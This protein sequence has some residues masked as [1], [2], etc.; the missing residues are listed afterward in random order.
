MTISNYLRNGFFINW[1]DIAMIAQIII[2]CY[3]TEIG[4]IFNFIFCF[5]Q[6]HSCCGAENKEEENEYIED[7]LDKACHKWMEFE[8]KEI[9]PEKI[10]DYLTESMARIHNKFYFEEEEENEYGEYKE[11]KKKWE[12]INKMKKIAIEKLIKNINLD[13]INTT[14]IELRDFLKKISQIS[15][16]IANFYSNTYRTRP[17]G[18]WGDMNFIAAVSNLDLNWGNIRNMRALSRTRNY[19]RKVFPYYFKD[20]MARGGISIKELFKIAGSPLINKYEEEK[21]YYIEEKMKDMLT[22]ILKEKIIKGVRKYMRKEEPQIIDFN[23]VEEPEE[24]ERIKRIKEGRGDYDPDADPDELNKFGAGDY[25][26]DA[27]PDL[28]N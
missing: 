23:F 7:L 13:I 15:L 6:N 16:I 18:N 1:G 27:D 26:P 14:T 19:A 8:P 10:E 25:D 20:V 22:K 12:R 2:S 17:E 3:S 5:H 9:K 24:L 28:N 21:K 4:E 11:D